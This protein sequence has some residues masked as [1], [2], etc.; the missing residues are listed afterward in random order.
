MPPRSGPLAFDRYCSRDLDRDTIERAYSAWAPVYDGVCG[1]IFH[2]GRRAAV[3]AACAVGGRTLEIGVGTGL[4]FGAYAR[5]GTRVVGIDL[6]QAM[7]ARAETKRAT[8]RYPHVESLQVMDA[9]ELAFPDRAFDSAVAQFVI[10]LVE[11]PERVLDECA[12]VVRPGGEIILMS[13]LY[14]ERGLTAAIERFA[15]RH[16]RA[17]G[18]R[19]EFPFAR[20]QAWADRHGGVTLLERR[21][22]R[23]FYTLVRFRV[24]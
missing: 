6:S 11:N 8:G 15:A 16:T 17:I 3:E 7:L 20:L 21:P 9:H 18:L 10:T 2:H 19:P 12:R 22:V 4:S 23:P 13:H 24:A 5:T 14:S 1:P